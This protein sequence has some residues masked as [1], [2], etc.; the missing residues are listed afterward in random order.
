MPWQSETDVFEIFPW[1]RNF[2][3]GLEDIDDLLE[4]LKQ[5]IEGCDDGQ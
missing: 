3:T 2:E 1:N 4:D 5:A